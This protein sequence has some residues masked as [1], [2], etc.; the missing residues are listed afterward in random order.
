MV[1][2]IIKSNDNFIVNYNLNLINQEYNKNGKKGINNYIQNNILECYFISNN[3][4]KQISASLELVSF[5]EVQNIIKYRCGTCH[6]KNPTFE[7]IEVAPK[8][9]IYDSANDII[10]NLKLI[11]AQAIDAEIMPPNNLTGITNQERE[12]LRIWIEQGANI[13]N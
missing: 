10:K 8:G 7:G 4:K 9:V 13:N 3:D 12:K 11:Q 5:N 6:A 1:N 2:F